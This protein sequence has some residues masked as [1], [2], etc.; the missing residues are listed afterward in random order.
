MNLKRHLLGGALTITAVLCAVGALGQSPPPPAATAAD[1]MV[2]LG[3]ILDMSGPYAELTGKGSAA[4]AQMAIDDFGG[5]VLDKPIKLVV[6]ELGRIGGSGGLIA[7]GRHGAPV[8]PF[9]CPGMY[10]GYVTDDRIVYTA[11][12]DEPYKAS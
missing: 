11:I 9:N 2:K 6:A 1:P 10:R 7:V 3:L 4:A 12:Y 5:K 8:L